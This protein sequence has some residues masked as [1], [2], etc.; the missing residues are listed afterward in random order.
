[1]HIQSRNTMSN[2]NNNEGVGD[3]IHRA[4]NKVTKGKLKSCGGCDRRR[5]WLN[6]NIKSSLLYTKTIGAK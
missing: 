2:K 1:M 4:I 6:R 5:E 3:V